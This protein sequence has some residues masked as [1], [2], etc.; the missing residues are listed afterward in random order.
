MKKQSCP[1]TESNPSVFIHHAAYYWLRVDMN[2]YMYIL[3]AIWTWI[4][5]ILSLS[6]Y[7]CMHRPCWF[8]CFKNR[9]SWAHSIF[10]TCT[11]LNLLWKCVHSKIT[12]TMICTLVWEF[13]GV[14]IV[15]IVDIITKENDTFY[16][17]AL[18]SSL[19]SHV[20]CNIDVV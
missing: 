11:S 8:Q 2:T 3:L 9:S 17:N 14:L 13:S 6:L 18:K 15:V 1:R 10:S 7:N 12:Y 5:F 20:S 19:F 16:W 4:F